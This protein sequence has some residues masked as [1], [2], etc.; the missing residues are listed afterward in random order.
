[1]RASFKAAGATLMDRFSK[2]L[3]SK[4]LEVSIAAAAISS[5]SLEQFNAEAIA[6]A[7]YNAGSNSMTS[8]INGLN[9][10]MEAVKTAC[11]TAGSE[12]MSK[13][14]DGM[15]SQ[16]PYVQ[17]A[18]ALIAASARSTVEGE[19]AKLKVEVQKWIDENIDFEPSE[20]ERA[21]QQLREEYEK[22]GLNPEDSSR[23]A[24]GLDLSFLGGITPTSQQI[25]NSDNKNY[26]DIDINGVPMNRTSQLADDLARRLR[27]LGIT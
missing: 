25:W 8:Y 23:L 5:A 1:M 6:E 27:Q 2:G 3:L 16:A 11:Y 17:Q 9:S 18:A 7:Y 22:I 26:I 19:L 20:L 21:L 13:F 10:Q 15:N 14:A 4:A 12:V 24:Q